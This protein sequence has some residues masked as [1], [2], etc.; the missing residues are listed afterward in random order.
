MDNRFLHRIDTG[1]W[2][3]YPPKLDELRMKVTSNA[4]QL[5]EML[6]LV[7]KNQGI[8]TSEQFQPKNRT[9]FGADFQRVPNTYYSHI[10]NGIAYVEISDELY[11]SGGW[12][13]EIIAFYF[14]GTSTKKLIN[15]FQQLK[16]NP[17]VKEVVL[18]INSPGGEAF[19]LNEAANL[20]AELN[21]TKPVTAYVSG[22][23]ASGGYFL[24]SRAGRIVTDAQALLGSIGVVSGWADF[25]DFYAKL[26]II[27]EE[28]T[29]ENAPFKRL[30]I[31]NEEHR[32]IFKNTLNGMEKVFIQSVAKGRNVSVEKVK[33]DFGKG[34]VMAGHL[35]VKAG[36]AD[37]VGSLD[38]VIKNIT[39]NSNK[40]RAANAGAE[41]EIT[42]GIKDE[43]VAFAQK[44]GF[45][46]QETSE[47]ETDDET[48]AQS[49]GD[50]PV[51]ET[52]AVDASAELKRVKAELE[53]EKQ[54][55]LQNEAEAFVSAEITAGRLSPAEKDAFLANY[56]QAAADDKSS[57]LAT[58]SRVENLKT[59]QGKRPASGLTEEVL[60]PGNQIKVLTNEQ[61]KNAQL[62]AEIEAQT[63]E[64][65]ATV[66]PK[67]A[68]AKS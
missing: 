39:K 30:D 62:D 18:I 45:K 60:Q 26:G 28:M 50:K 46:V 52:S 51:Q 20:I 8:S 24:A 5:D 27:Y 68:K 19:G 61:D 67:V 36:M 43:F 15:D 55:R 13:D 16:S 47:T 65:V 4:V 14:G 32:Q 37:E 38:S 23:A 7:E 11:Y 57:P 48:V 66:E 33:A 63:S 44:L 9:I 40:N 21:K 25:K 58:G 53:A 10:S 41:G 54:Q 49:E 31:R 12:I 1:F 42:M 2:A 35:A 59:A 56:L 22:Y 3:L 29:S 34:S 17:L 64:Y 6:K